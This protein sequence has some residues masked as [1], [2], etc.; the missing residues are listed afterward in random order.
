MD[1]EYDRYKKRGDDFF[2]QGDYSNAL[3]QYRNC[4]EVPNFDNDPYAKGRI[5][6][7]TKLTKLRD[8][9]TKLLN[10]GK[11]E[12]AVVLLKQILDENPNDPVTKVTLTD[13][14]SDEAT[15]L[16]AQK[17]YIEAKKR[18][19]EAL[20][21]AVKP[22]L[23]RVQIQNCD[24]FIKVQQKP[25]PP[26]QVVQ[27]KAKEELP[28]PIKSSV[29]TSKPIQKKQE[30]VAEPKKEENKK[31]TAPAITLKPTPT[32]KRRIVPKI[33]T[34]VIGLGAG[35]YAYLLNS[36][37]QTKLNN[38]SSISQ[39]TDPDGD[40]VILNQSAF[41]QWETSYKDVK[42]FQSNKTTMNACLG[43]AGAAVVAEIILFALPKPKKQTGFHFHP[44]TKNVGLALQYRF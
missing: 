31:A 32:P 15:K 10:D 5:A 14:W 27:D 11:G 7:V 9:A 25:E 30:V 39:T 33:L 17:N 21:Y 24:D 16:Y 19:Q 44:T 38:L 13:Y 40:N 43:V 35:G 6:L 26:V 41:N 1:E 3:K 23:I 22:D 12:E 28:A 36:Q 29:T 37:Y 20:Q 8:D 42:S 4:L 2:V 18:Y 34:A